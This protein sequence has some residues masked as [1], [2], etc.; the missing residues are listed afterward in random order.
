MCADTV[1]HRGPCT[2]APLPPECSRWVSGL[3][4]GSHRP[5]APPSRVGCGP[6]PTVVPIP[7][8]G[9]PEASAFTCSCSCR[10]PQASDV[11]PSRWDSSPPGHCHCRRPSWWP[12]LLSQKPPGCGT[13][14]SQATLPSWL[15]PLTRRFFLNKYTYGTVLFLSHDF[16]NIFFFSLLHRESAVYN[17]YNI[18]NMC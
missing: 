12:L 1:L 5:W 13:L 4:Q 3:C 16:L 17:T 8:L 18:Q 7:T 9:F 2:P 15:G 14:P 11:P 6:L 10:W